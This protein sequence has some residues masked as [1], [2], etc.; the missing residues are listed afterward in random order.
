[1]IT[2]RQTDRQVNYRVAR[3]RLKTAICILKP[4]YDFF[5][6]KETELRGLNVA[7]LHHFR[8]KSVHFLNEIAIKRFLSD[9]TRHHVDSVNIMQVSEIF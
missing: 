4:Q 1:M 5:F 6:S 9:D 7:L 3:S 8:R 2:D